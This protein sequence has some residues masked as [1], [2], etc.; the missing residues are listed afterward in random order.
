MRDGSGIVLGHRLELGRREV[1][2]AEGDAALEVDGCSPDGAEMLIFASCCRD[3]LS[4]M[5]V[6]A[7]H[8]T[9]RSED[10]AR[11]RVGARPS[12]PLPTSRPFTP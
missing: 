11:G 2:R 10:H 4:V 3:V 1:G 5:R 9:L 7:L 12:W 8:S 6:P